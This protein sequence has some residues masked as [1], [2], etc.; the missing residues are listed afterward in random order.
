MV[1]KFKLT[2]SRHSLGSK[3]K[4]IRRRN[5][6]SK[7][8]GFLREFFTSNITTPAGSCSANDQ[9]ACS[10]T[11]KISEI[12]QQQQ[13]DAQFDTNRPTVSPA[14]DNTNSTTQCQ[15]DTNYSNL[16]FKK[17]QENY[18]AV[19]QKSKGTRCGGR[20]KRTFKFKK[21]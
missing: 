21:K 14:A 1:F 2:H 4:R 19:M 20:K 9:A 10:S 5:K 16:Q 7:K 11:N 15:S 17:A 13:S 18:C 12:R 6:K 8:G 3:K